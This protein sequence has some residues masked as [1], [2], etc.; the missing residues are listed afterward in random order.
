MTDDVILSFWNSFQHWRLPYLLKTTTKTCSSILL[1]ENHHKNLL[2]PTAT[3]P[4]DPIQILRNFLF[5]F[6]VF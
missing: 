1:P 6:Y 2:R 4:T 3:K 5:Q